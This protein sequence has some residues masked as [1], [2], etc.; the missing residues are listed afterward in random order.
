MNHPSVIS[1][2]L[3][4]QNLVYN[5][6]IHN[7]FLAQIH[8]RNDCLNVLAN[9]NISKLK[10]VASE[11]ANKV[12]QTS[13]RMSCEMKTFH[14]GIIHL[15]AICLLLTLI[16]KKLFLSAGPALKTDCRGVVV[17]SSFAD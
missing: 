8:D 4:K 6:Y 13:S 9:L 3:V 17:E 12:L 14:S 1:S 11:Q 2:K 10:L 5:L 7:E 15:K 16:D